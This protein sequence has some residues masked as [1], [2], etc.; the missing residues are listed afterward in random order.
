M[1]R[2][3]EQRAAHELIL[4]D[5]CFADRLYLEQRAH[6]EHRATGYR[7]TLAE[8]LSKIISRDEIATGWHERPSLD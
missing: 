5:V 6:S 8:V 2:T 4:T 7:P 1:G 3:K